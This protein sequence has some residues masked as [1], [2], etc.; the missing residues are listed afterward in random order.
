MLGAQ[1]ESALGPIIGTTLAMISVDLEAR[2]LGKT[3]ATIEHI[4]LPRLAENLS[5]RLRL[6][7]GADL[8]E[9]AA[10]RVREMML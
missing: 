2:R 4:D 6:V 5:G 1:V 10:K 9:V 8:A 3:K 7:V